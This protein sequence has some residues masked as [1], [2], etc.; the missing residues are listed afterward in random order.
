MWP[1]VQSLNS[2]ECPKF[3]FQVSLIRTVPALGV[4]AGFEA[5]GRS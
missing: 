1:K 4:L 5:I 2:V 3:H